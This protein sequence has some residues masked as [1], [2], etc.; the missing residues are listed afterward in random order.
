MKA[1]ILWEGQLLKEPGSNSKTIAIFH[2]LPEAKIVPGI[3]A[4]VH[5]LTP[6]WDLLNFHQLNQL[7][8]HLGLINSWPLYLKGDFG[9]VVDILHSTF[10]FILEESFQDF[11]LNEYIHIYERVPLWCQ[12]IKK[13]LNVQT[14]RSFCACGISLNKW[15]A[16]LCFMLITKEKNMFLCQHS[17]PSPPLHCGFMSLDKMTHAHQSS[18]RLMTGAYS[19][20]SLKMKEKRMQH[21]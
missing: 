11:F 20:K 2:H 7:D 12:M 4:C 1:G 18:F 9:W 16:I 21:T 10:K 19:F 8:R 5:V 14:Y 3:S 13:Y 6:L 15:V 17:L